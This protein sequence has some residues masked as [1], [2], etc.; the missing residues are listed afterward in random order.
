MKH[1]VVAALFAVCLGGC[2]YYQPLFGCD[3]VI[4]REVTSPDRHHIATLSA[5]SCGA[6]TR[7]RQ[8]V[9]IRQSS[10]KFDADEGQVF[11]V[12]GDPQINLVWVGEASLRVECSGCASKDI[13]LQVIVWRGI[14]VSY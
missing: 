1:C 5:G 12:M 7:N 10:A 8:R 13:V 6:T 4:T 11:V 3:E 14:S 2:W 9:T